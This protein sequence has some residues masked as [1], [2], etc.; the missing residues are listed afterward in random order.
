MVPEFA[1][2]WSPSNEVYLTG[3]MRWQIFAPIMLLQILNLFWYFLIWRIVYRMIVGNPLADV[4]E[5]GETDEEE[6]DDSAAKKK[7]Q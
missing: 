6:E 4:R 7:K 5:E 3:W 1:K 2:R